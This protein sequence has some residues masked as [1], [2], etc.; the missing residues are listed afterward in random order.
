VP[1]ALPYHQ[2]DLRGGTCYW[3][4]LFGDRNVTESR[5]L[6]PGGLRQAYPL[7]LVRMR[8]AAQTGARYYHGIAH[9]LRTIVRE[10]G[11]RGLYSGL[12]ATLLQARAPGRRSE[13]VPPGSGA[14]SAHARPRKDSGGRVWRAHVQQT[15]RGLSEARA[16]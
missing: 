10:E 2:Y 8:L 16:G 9:A 6:K 7:D 12:G 11:A 4:G 5:G 14:L 3:T 13:R 1:A 15:R